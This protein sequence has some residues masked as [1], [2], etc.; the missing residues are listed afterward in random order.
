VK[1]RRW[2]F[3]GIIVLAIAQCFDWISGAAI[4]WSASGWLVD[5]RFALG[6][7]VGAGINLLGLVAFLFRRLRWGTPALA[8]VQLGNI[9]F[10]L[11]AAVL[12]SPVWLLFGTAPAA[13]T[14]VL[15]LVLQKKE[16]PSSAGSLGD[17]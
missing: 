15:I 5:P 4:A 14:L 11:A 2:L 17:C 1:R 13:I 10:S 9:I 6:L 12:V 3:V 8:A 16:A 7:W